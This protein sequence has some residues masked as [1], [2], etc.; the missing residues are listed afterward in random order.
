MT[1]NLKSEELRLRTYIFFPV[2]SISSHIYS[3]GKHEVQ[4]IMKY[5]FHQ[6]VLY[7]IDLILLILF[8]YFV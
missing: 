2:Y 3:I 8:V 5:F 4:P 7:W 1:T 6:P